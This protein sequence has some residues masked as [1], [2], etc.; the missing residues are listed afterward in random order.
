MHELP[1]HQNHTKSDSPGIASIFRELS[2]Y[3]L[4]ADSGWFSRI[5]DKAIISGNEQLINN[6]LVQKEYIYIF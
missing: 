1:R 6:K 4:C 2:T 5:Q 3:R